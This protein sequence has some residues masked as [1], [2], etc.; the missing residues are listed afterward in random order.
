MSVS[1]YPLLK[2]KKNLRDERGMDFYSFYWVYRIRSYLFRLAISH[3]G[4]AAS[5]FLL[6]SFWYILLAPRFRLLAQQC[7]DGSGC[8]DDG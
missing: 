4:E 8:V 5:F 1:Y 2:W 3:V 7:S 6:F